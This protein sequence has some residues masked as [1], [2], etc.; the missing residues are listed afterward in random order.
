MEL[1]L[2]KGRLAVV[3]VL[4]WSLLLGTHRVWYRQMKSVRNLT[5]GSLVWTVSTTDINKIVSIARSFKIPTGTSSVDILDFLKAIASSYFF[6][7]RIPPG[8]S[9]GNSSRNSLWRFLLEF[10]LKITS[11]FSSKNVSRNFIQECHLS[12]RGF[13]QKHILGFST[14]NS[15]WNFWRFFS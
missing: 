6:V 15:R 12:A 3:H 7:I 4:F 1:F 14:G 2:E 13:P 9:P 11:G 5:F 10:H 8:I